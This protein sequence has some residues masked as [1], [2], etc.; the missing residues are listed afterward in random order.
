MAKSFSL[1][2]FL[3]ADYF[4]LLSLSVSP[5]IL[6][7]HKG[8]NFELFVTTIWASAFGTCTDAGFGAKPDEKRAETGKPHHGP[9]TVSAFRPGTSLRFARGP[10]ERTPECLVDQ[11]LTVLMAKRISVLFLYFQLSEALPEGSPP[12]Q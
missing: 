4:F 7:R 8:S 1:F 9:N 11:T 10:S 12:S 5:P 2:W 3:K 6:P